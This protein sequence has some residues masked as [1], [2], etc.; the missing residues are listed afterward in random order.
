MTTKLRRREEGALSES[1]LQSRLWCWFVGVVVALTFMAN[2]PRTV[3]QASDDLPEIMVN[4]VEPART[5]RDT[6]SVDVLVQ[7]TV[8]RIR[9]RDVAL[10]GERKPLMVSVARVDRSVAL[11][12]RALAS[13]ETLEIV[14]PT[15]S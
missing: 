14:T 8:T 9:K 12:G 6:C 4:V 2:A 1:K 3:A 5:M 13:G 7:A 11:H 10:R 15:G